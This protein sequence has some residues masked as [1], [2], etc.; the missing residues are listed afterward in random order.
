MGV[1]YLNGYLNSKCK[2]G[3][4]QIN[5]SELSNKKIAIDASIYMYNFKLKGDLI[6][7]MYKMIFTFRSYNIIPVFVFDGKPPPEKKKYIIREKTK[8]KRS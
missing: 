2:K 6:E 3:I 7:Y 4:R 1:R 5:L 8:K